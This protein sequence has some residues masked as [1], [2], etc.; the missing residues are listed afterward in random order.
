MAAPPGRHMSADDAALRVMTF[1][2]R[3]NNPG[4]GEDAWPNRREMA[5]SM[6][7]FHDADVAG[8]QEALKGQIDD[9][10]E[11]LP[12]YAW[13]GV[14]RADGE[15]AGEFSPIFF[16]VDRLELLRDD[17]FWLSET[18]AVPGSKS[19]DAAI[20]RIATWAVFRDRVTDEEIF[21]LNTHFDHIGEE[22]REESAEL[23][24]ARLDS[25]AGGRPVVVTGDFNTTP[26][27]APY[28]TL[29]GGM[30]QD[31]MTVSQ[32]PHHGPTSTWN[33]FEA[34]VPN[35]RIDYIFVNQGF[36]V[37]EHGILA[38]TWEDRFPSDHLPVLAEVAVRR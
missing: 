18:P 30:L 6:I 15:E 24:V 14:G 8:L 10:Q 4:D 26:Q 21:V 11:L 28:V 33:G 16:R 29:T 31:A 17:T 37:I 5:A 22:A 27:T 25:L 13:T 12:N 36:Q 7:R 38:D 32:H 1:N 19:W 3:Y 23:I 9:L 35:R 2:I 34:I 20:E